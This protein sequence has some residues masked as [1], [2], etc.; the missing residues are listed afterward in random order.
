MPR[1]N[2]PIK[3]TKPTKQ[4]LQLR[5]TCV[6]KTSY[7]TRQRA[8]RAADDLQKLHDTDA[9]QRPYLCTDCGQWHLTSG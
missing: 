3:P 9:P 6:R 5:T 7:P 4:H 1:R 2:N 8:E